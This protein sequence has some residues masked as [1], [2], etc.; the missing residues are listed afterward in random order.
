MHIIGF[1]VYT[2]YRNVLREEQLSLRS[3]RNLINTLLIN[4]IT[5]SRLLFASLA[6]ACVVFATLCRQSHIFAVEPVRSF[7]HSLMIHAVTDVYKSVP[8]YA[9]A[10]SCIYH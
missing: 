3:V 7:I 2:H 4:G 6:S 1:I 9:R 8:A 10:L 5:E